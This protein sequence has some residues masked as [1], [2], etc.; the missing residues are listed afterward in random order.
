MVSVVPRKS[1][2]T[3]TAPV[4]RS[5][6]SG[7]GEPRVADLCHLSSGLRAQF[8]LSLEGGQCGFLT[9]VDSKEGVTVVPGPLCYT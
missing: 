8:S 4:V 1:P 9:S 6:S 2:G 7:V 3:L 5:M